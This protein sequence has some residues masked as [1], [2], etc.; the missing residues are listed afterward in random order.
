M[1]TYHS[2]SGAVLIRA[3]PSTHLEAQLFLATAAQGLYIATYRDGT[4]R[5]VTGWGTVLGLE[6]QAP[7]ARA[8]YSSGVTVLKI[9][10]RSG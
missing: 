6:R 8:G 3:S 9:A 10:V 5:D 1:E 4:A 2:C 7:S